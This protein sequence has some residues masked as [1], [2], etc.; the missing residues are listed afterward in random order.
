MKLNL[1]LNSWAIEEQTFDPIIHYYP[2]VAGH[3]SKTQIQ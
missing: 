1:V 3:T 2:S